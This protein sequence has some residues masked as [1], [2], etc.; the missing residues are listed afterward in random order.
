MGRKRW[1][2]TGGLG[3]VAFALGVGAW[4]LQ[5]DIAYGRIATGYAAKQTCSCV[6]VSGRPLESCLAD[7]P[8]DARQ[9]NVTQAG[10]TVHAS[11]MFGAIKAK[12]V[13]EDGFGCRI[14]D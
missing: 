14:L 13:Y 4:S 8:E 11:V 2:W 3:I 5:D 10:D 9:I 7:Y 6:H 1:M 12:A